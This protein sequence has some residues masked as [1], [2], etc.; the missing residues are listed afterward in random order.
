[1]KIMKFPLSTLLLVFFL[2]L[3]SCRTVQ[4][5]E[6]SLPR[7]IPPGIIGETAEEDP[8][9]EEGR[10]PEL[11]EY[12][13]EAEDFGLI[14]PEELHADDPPGDYMIDSADEMLDYTAEEDV[15]PTELPPGEDE[16]L[17]EDEL[18]VEEELLLEDEL[19]A[20][21][22]PLLED[23]LAAE[24]PLPLPPPP[25]TPD[26]PPQP[27]P[28]PPAPPPL[29]PP[30]PPPVIVP[31]APPPPVVVPPVQPP[32]EPPLEPPEPP[33]FLRPAEPEIDP[34]ILQPLEPLTPPPTP[35]RR[36]LP[37]IPGEEIVISR[38]VRLT[39]GQILEIPFWGTGWVYLGELGGRRG[40]SYSS[41]RLDVEAGATIGQTFVFVAETAGT[42]ILRFFRQDFIRDYLLNDHVQVIVGERS[43]DTGR[44][45]I[46]ARDRV[47]AQPRWPAER[48]HT[49]WGYFEDVPPA[50]LIPVVPE[51]DRDIDPDL[52]EPWLE[53]PAIRPPLPPVESPDEFMRRARQEFD[54]GRIVQAI[55]ILD[56][57]SQYHPH[58]LTDELLWLL[59][60]FFEANSPARD[61][62]QSL[63]YYRRLVREFPQSVRIPDARR[64]IA[65]LERFYFNIR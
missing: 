21:E 13:D 44:V 65:F 11:D 39:V 28:T 41:R 20:E 25:V 12:V 52:A 53:A 36:E 54:A 27:E 32:P 24:E 57:M 10:L 63:E 19:A 37:E 64:R 35:P 48:G 26:P 43:E 6:P 29:P 60:Q 31:P 47:I 30:P 23:E 4:E 49:P 3:I 8:L 22:E 56:D 33:P 7:D 42:Y 50:A 46:P 58:W 5:F 61:I 51:R 16:L 2:A 1:M 9:L 45:G 55:S 59:G 14:F 38:V 17:L 18:A 62:R 15:E 34:R 40:L